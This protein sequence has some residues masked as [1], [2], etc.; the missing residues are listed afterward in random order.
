M[1]DVRLYNK[2]SNCP[3]DLLEFFMYK[4]SIKTEKNINFSLFVIKANLDL[5]N[6]NI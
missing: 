1:F 5:K 2:T 4:E 3:A 6:R